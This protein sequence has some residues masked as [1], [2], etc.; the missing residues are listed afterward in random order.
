MKNGRKMNFMTFMTV[1]A[2]SLSFTLLILDRG[3]RRLVHHQLALLHDH[4]LEGH[5]A[6]EDLHP[7]LALTVFIF[8]TVLARLPR[9]VP[10]H[11]GL[12]WMAH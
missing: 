4:S 3:I 10:R 7:H 5:A 8:A 11:L 9:P 12:E 2:L 1:S 6:A